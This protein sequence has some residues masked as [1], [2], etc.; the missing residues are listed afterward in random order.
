MELNAVNGCI[1]KILQDFIQSGENIG[2]YLIGMLTIAYIDAI[3]EENIE[4]VQTVFPKLD[5]SKLR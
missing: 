3:E 5:M 1:D 2:I 4:T